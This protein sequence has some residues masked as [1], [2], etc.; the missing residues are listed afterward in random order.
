MGKASR[1]KGKRGEREVVRML[2]VLDSKARRGRQELRG[3]VES[4]VV[5]PSW[6]LWIEVKNW[7]SPMYIKALVQAL[8]D[9]HTHEMVYGERRLP[10]AWCKA[11]RKPW[12]VLLSEQEVA[13][14]QI[15]GLVR[16]TSP[17][18]QE[19]S[20]AIQLI[21]AKNGPSVVV[22][23]PEDWVTNILVARPEAVIMALQDARSKNLI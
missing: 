11:T 14:W 9:A 21:Q 12:V 2:R 19:T 1:D 13:D 10:M 16:V 22:L 3:D 6:P 20:K 5:L 17:V 7:K 18:V 8:D 4:D 23:H 15:W